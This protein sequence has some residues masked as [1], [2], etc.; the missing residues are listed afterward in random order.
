MI[1]NSCGNLPGCRLNY[2]AGFKKVRLSYFIDY[3]TG[4]YII[5]Y[6]N[7]RITRINGNENYYPFS[8]IRAI[9]WPKSINDDKVP[10]IIAHEHFEVYGIRGF[11]FSYVR[12]PEKGQR[13]PLGEAYLTT[14]IKMGHRIRVVETPLSLAIHPQITQGDIQTLL[15]TTAFITL[16]LDV[17]QL[18]LMSQ[19]IRRVYEEKGGQNLEDVED[20]NFILTDKSNKE[21]VVVIPGQPHALRSVRV[22]FVDLNTIT[23]S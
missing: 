11:F 13:T 9:T 14:S 16:G 22:N 2:Q 20:S 1:N 7:E 17:F 8:D 18:N 5:H 15:R 12:I 6:M 10:Q 23:K 21:V 3:T 4:L 19:S